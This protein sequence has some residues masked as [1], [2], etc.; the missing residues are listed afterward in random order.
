MHTPAACGR[1]LQKWRQLDIAAALMP[2]ATAAAGQTV[3]PEEAPPSAKFLPA[4]EQVMRPEHAA[5]IAAALRKMEDAKTPAAALPALDAALD[6]LGEPS[7]IRG[8]VQYWRAGILMA[9]NHAEAEAAIEESIRLLPDYSAP[10]IAAAAVYVYA[11]QPGRGADY[12]LRATRID[13]A[14]TRK[15]DDYEVNNLLR[16]LHF[17]GQSRRADA[18]SARLLEIGWM[19][20]ALGSASSLAMSAMKERSRAGN[21]AGARAL[22]TKLLDPGHSYEL[23]VDNRYKAVWDVVERWGGPRLASQW[24]IYLR[25]ARERWTA[26]KD[27]ETARDYAAALVEAGHD[28]T[29]VREFSAMFEG[30]LDET[31]DQSLQFVVPLLADALGREGRWAD[32]ERLFIK[33]QAIWPL[34]NESNP[35]SL[36]IAANRARSL[37]HRGEFSLSLRY[38]EEALAL[39]RKW[40]VNPDAL[41]YMTHYRACALHR[42]GRND[43]A[44]LAAGFVIASARVDRIAN[45]QLCLGDYQA[46]RAALL[47]GL[48]EEEQ[49]TGVLLFMQ[50]EGGRPYPSAHMRDSAA[51]AERLRSDPQLKAEV[52]KLGRVLPY[53]SRAGAPPE[54][55]P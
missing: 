42:V 50:P 51:Q 4:P 2:V 49:R 45:L 40:D 12:F 38:M 46:A 48:K 13:P 26:S 17:A 1:R 9:N 14:S 24:T 3:L 21:A 8:L 11:N 34:S 22:A 23:L 16:R 43:E 35:N 54:A 30:K 10:L 36:N 15:I 5:V 7:S 25:E 52:L 44:K 39:A 19:G 32:V 33:S 41:V 20:S 37:Y 18:V 29:L 53:N 47:T 55:A 27:V 28:R 6:K 31:G